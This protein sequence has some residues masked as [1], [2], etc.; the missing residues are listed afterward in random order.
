MK[1]KFNIK[2]KY[3]VT[4]LTIICAL[5]IVLTLV[6][7]NFGKPLKKVTATVVI[8]MQKGMNSVGLWFSDR[9]DALKEIAD[10]QA[11]NKKLREELAELKLMN[12]IFSARQDE[13]ERL[14]E[15]YDLDDAYSDYDKVAARI[16]AKDTG[17]WFSVFTIDKGAKD[18]LAVNMNVIADGGLV[19]IVTEVGD[20]YAKVTTIITDGINVSARFAD[21]QE[22][23][24][25]EGDL[26]LID[27][28]VIKVSNIDKKADVK[29][30]DM[31]MTSYISDKYVPGLLIGYITEIS[32]DSN[33]LTKSGYVDPVVDFSYLEEVLVITQLKDTGETEKKNN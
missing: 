13:L 3:L 16:I 8:P 4:I 10:L 20:N 33:N 15:L 11:E 2:T 9:A 29:V 30:G 31:L 23:C 17:N 18:G 27:E 19:G 5:L 14:W 28:G 7:D 12:T 32:E 1:K 24:V 22:L 6:N 26:K 21:S 25:T